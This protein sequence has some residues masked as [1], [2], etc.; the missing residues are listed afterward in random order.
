[1]NPWI[2]KL[3]A[4]LHH[5]ID[6]Q[7]V[8]WRM[9]EEHKIAQELLNFIFSERFDEREIEKADKLAAAMS[10]VIVAPQKQEIKERFEEEINGFF[11]KNP[12]Q[13]FYRDAFSL[14]RE[15]VDL[16]IDHNQVE[17]FFKKIEGI[18]NKIT[19]NSEKRA[20]YAFLLIWRFLPEEFKI[21]F[22]LTQQILVP[23]IIQ[24][25]TI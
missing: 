10:R 22:L 18:L 2:R 23:L 7:L 16:E 8:M 12:S 20:K 21:G 17:D 25:M 6:E 14:K 4:I 1:M 11:S 19:S 24:F 5:L 3:K 15:S 13:I 9:R